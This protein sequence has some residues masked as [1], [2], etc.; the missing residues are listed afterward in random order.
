MVLTNSD[1]K[2]KFFSF[3]TCELFAGVAQLEQP[4][5]KHV[6]EGMLKSKLEIRVQ[7][8]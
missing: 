4:S 3:L 6:R 5:V 2:I 7:K 1:S 8:K